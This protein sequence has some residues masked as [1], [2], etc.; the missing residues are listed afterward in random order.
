MDTNN[1]KIT[2]TGAVL[3]AS[4]LLSG[5]ASPSSEDQFGNAVRQ[6][7]AAQKHVP[8]EQQARQLPTLDGRKAET[9][10]NSYRK[11]TGNPTRITPDMSGGVGLG[12]GQ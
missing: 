3:A 6:M 2:V 9:G 8:P 11:D 12:L 5:C 10:Y 7:V 1:L 4:V